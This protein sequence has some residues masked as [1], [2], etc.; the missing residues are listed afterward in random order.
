MPWPSPFVSWPN[1]KKE[2]K[3]D[4]L[5]LLNLIN[6]FNTLN[7][8]D[9]TPN[10]CIADDQHIAHQC[11]VDLCGPPANN[12]SLFITDQ[13]FDQ[14]IPD[15]MYDKFGTI[16][17]KIRE[18]VHLNAKKAKELIKQ[19]KQK[20]LG[21][22]FLPTFDHWE[23]RDYTKLSSLVYYPM[24]SVNINP[25]KKIKDRI[26]L[27]P[28][29]PPGMD[30]DY[31][32]GLE[33]YLVLKKQLIQ[34]NLTLSVSMPDYL[35]AQEAAQRITEF[36]SSFKSEIEPLKGKDGALNWPSSNWI[37]YENINK[38]LKSTPLEQFS[39]N[40]LISPC[41]KDELHHYFF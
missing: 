28:A 33:Q 5:S 35:S 22:D 10:Q 23:T 37:D 20:A 14:D 9:V 1:K 36:W 19:L 7:R 38:K 27:T 17:P 12:S 30:Q 25:L 4:V 16:E 40:E 31:L 41:K 26:Q 34:D 39:R 3:E 6:E 29:P 18:I 32:K 2:K 13:H 8:T 11:A 21:D 15:D 24:H